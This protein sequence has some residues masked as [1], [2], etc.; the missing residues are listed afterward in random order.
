MYLLALAAVA[1]ASVF[2]LRSREIPDW[3]SAGLLAS[4]LVLLALGRHPVDGQGV[5]WGVGVATL[6]ALV[7]FSLNALGGGDVKLLIALG[8][9]L[10]VGAFIPFALAMTIAGGVLALRARRRGERE[11]AYAP[12]MLIGLLALAPLTWMAR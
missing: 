1:L 4:C 8:A 6:G 12:A 3:I 11:I 9:T 7:L 10:G 2:D 5:L